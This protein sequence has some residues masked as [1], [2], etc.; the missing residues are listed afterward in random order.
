MA[1]SARAARTARRPQTNCDANAAADFFSAAEEQAADLA[2][3][4]EV[5]STA[6]IAVD[7]VDLDEADFA[8][9]LRKLAQLAGGEHGFGF[10]ARDVAHGDGAIFGDD[11]VAQALDAFEAVGSDGAAGKVDGG[12]GVAE[13]EGDGG[14]V[15]LA[16]KDGG[17]QMLAGVLL[18]VVEAALPVDVAFDFGADGERLADEMPDLA[19]VVFFDGVDGDI[20]GG[21]AGRDGAE[22]AG[23]EGLAAAGGV[24]GGAVEGDLP[25]GFAFGTGEFANI[26]DDS[27]ER[28]QERIGVIEPFGCG[29]SVTPRPAAWFR[30][31]RKKGVSGEQARFSVMRGHPTVAHYSE[32]DLPY[33]IVTVLIW[34]IALASIV[35]D[36]GASARACRS[37]CGF[38]AGPCCWWRRDCCRLAGRSMR[39]ARAW[40]CICS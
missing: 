17:E 30:Q 8:G 26:G 33:M 16:Q 1:A 18:H 37:G 35:S 14:S 5:G 20:E 29:H 2:G 39:S 24:K 27:G 19:A 10:G 36:A 4:A 40:M 25:D 9:A 21:A 6:G 34:V 28:L 31:G 13:V 38:A 12:D 11:F 23:I 15:Q 3:G 7:A 32:P 22:E